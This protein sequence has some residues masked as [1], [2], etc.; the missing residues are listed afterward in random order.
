[1]YLGSI[2]GCR[3]RIQVPR[4]SRKIEFECLRR[5]A[6][7]PVTLRNEDESD[8]SHTSHVVHQST[9]DSTS[10]GA[11]YKSRFVGRVNPL[12]TVS[13]TETIRAH[14]PRRRK[15]GVGGHCRSGGMSDVSLQPIFVSRELTLLV[16]PRFTRGTQSIHQSTRHDSEQSRLTYLYFQRC[17]SETGGEGETKRDRWGEIIVSSGTSD[18]TYVSI[19]PPLGIDILLAL[20]A[21]WVEEVA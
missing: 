11:S 14:L 7:L 6:L 10:P 8:S 4:G 13:L 21:S 15:R 20:C 12:F 17:C 5:H 1:M 3:C 19:L 2:G 18:I 16:R 9:S